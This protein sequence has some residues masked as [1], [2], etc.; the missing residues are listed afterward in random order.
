MKA[1]KSHLA[2]AVLANPVAAKQLQDFL[3]DRSNPPKISVMMNSFKVLVQPKI[4][5]KASP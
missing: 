4:V 2:K 5:P 1:L 3:A